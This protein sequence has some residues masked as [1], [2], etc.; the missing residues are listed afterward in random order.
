[1]AGI[2]TFRSAK[3]PSLG[4]E[5]EGVNVEAGIFGKRLADYLSAHLAA[6]G[7]P[8]RAAVAEDFG[9]WLEIAHDEPYALAV[10]CGHVSDG[11]DDAFH[12]FLH[13]DKPHVRR[14]L[15]P[16]DTTAKTAALAKALEDI[17]RAD[18]DI[19]ELAWA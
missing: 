17:L 1:M 11:A 2:L 19:R 18:V 15:K 3:F 6:N 16:Y 13:P 9:W 14:W 10:C 12:C 8:V 4:T 5:E 7:F